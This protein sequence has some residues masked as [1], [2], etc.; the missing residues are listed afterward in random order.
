MGNEQVKEVIILAPLTEAL[1]TEIEQ[2]PRKLRNVSIQTADFYDVILTHAPHPRV[3]CN[4][5]GAML[6]VQP[7]GF[8]QIRRRLPVVRCTAPGWACAR[9]ILDRA[10]TPRVA[11]KNENVIKARD[12]HAPRNQFESLEHDV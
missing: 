4:R 1:K 8:V 12:E 11:R 9:Y 7:D 5:R 10:S 2:G 3:R 6:V